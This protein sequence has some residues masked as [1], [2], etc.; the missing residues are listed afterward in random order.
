MILKTPLMFCISM[1][2]YCN[3]YTYAF[4]SIKDTTRNVSTKPKR[5]YTTTVLT[6]DKPVIDGKLDDACWETGTW[7]GNFTQWVPNEGAKPS[8]PTE[9]KVLFDDNN[10]YVAI[11]AFDFEPEKIIR[12]AGRRDEFLGDIVGITFD[13]YHDHRTGFEFDITASGQKIDL[14]LTNEGWDVNWNAVWYGKNNMEDSAWTAEFEIP[15]SQ[16]RYSSENEQVW[17]M[18]CW[19]WIDR[20]QEESD[21]EPQSSTGPGILFQFGEL[22]GIKRL[23]AFRRIEVMPYSLGKLNTFRSEP[24]NPFKENGK[25]WLGNFGID[26]KIGLSSNFTADITVNPDF[27]QVESDPSVMNLTA[28]ETF[29]EEK[30]PFFLEGKNIFDFDFND[31]DIFYTRRIGQSPNYSPDLQNGEYADLPDKTAILSAV[32]LSGKTANGFAI[33]ILQ[34]LTANEQAAINSFGINKKINVEPLTNYTVVRAEQDFDKGNSVLG[35]IFTSTNRFIKDTHLEYLNRNAYT[36]GINFLHHWNEKEYFVDASFIGSFINGSNEAITILQGSS[37]R[38]YQRPDAD[39]L[40]FDSS[41]TRLSGYG[42][43]IKIGKGS[44]GLLR[45][46]TEVN[47]RSPG[48]ELNDLGYMQIADIIQQKN[49]VSYFVNQ[50]VSIFRTYSIGLSQFNNWNFGMNHL[51]SGAGVNIYLEFLNKW[52]ISNSLNYTT[53]TLDMHILRGGNAMLIPEIWAN[54]VYLKTDPSE[55]LFFDLNTFLSLSGNNSAQSF[56]ITPGISVMP[57]DILKL[58]LSIDYSSNINDLQYIDTKTINTGT[59]YLLG[60]IKQH[61]LNFTFRI[62]YNLTP[63]LSIQYYGSPFASAGRYSEFKVVKD[64]KNSEYKDRFSLLNPVLNG[65]TYQVSENNNHQVDYAF[66]DPDFNFFQ[67]RSNLVLRWEYLPGSQIYI[68]WAQERTN[69]IN[70]ANY[71]VYSALYK[72]TNIYP[73]NIFLIKLNYWFSI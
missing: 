71:T 54:N 32:K 70:P 30:R 18:H 63:E 14:L 21:W 39:Y 13:S 11:R 6:T 33:G 57:A 16:L 9:L 52:S 25:S 27:G 40:K 72:L 15:L 50:P 8:Q 69:Y 46:S 1:L 73:N 20:F 2:V 23:P 64:P 45:Y 36:G 53:P 51:S 5:I 43:I 59:R 35:G 67:F 68:V 4:S 60:K 41:R 22:H 17:G 65:N 26:A 34:S 3:T 62:D 42:G 7:A 19:R 28:F 38:Y 56:S 24:G 37:A 29:Y 55:K 31:A 61:T 49:A 47:W 44:V 10:I 12:K 58:S 48:L 66:S